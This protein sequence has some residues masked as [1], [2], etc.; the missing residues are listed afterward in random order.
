MEHGVTQKH[1]FP[2]INDYVQKDTN[3]GADSDIQF[4][5]SVKIVGSNIL[6]GSPRV[7]WPKR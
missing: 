1:Y 5:Y 7:F 2:D 3:N 4:G 6:V